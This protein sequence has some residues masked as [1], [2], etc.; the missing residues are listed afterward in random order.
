[1]NN[2]PSFLLSTIKDIGILKSIPLEDFS[3]LTNKRVKL[4]NMLVNQSRENSIQT[5]KNFLFIHNTLKNMGI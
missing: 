5:D 3:K 2:I 4:S 1:M